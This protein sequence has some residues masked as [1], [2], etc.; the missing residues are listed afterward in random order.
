MN[1]LIGILVLLGAFVTP[2]QFGVP[3]EGTGDASPAL[4]ACIRSGKPIR[5]RKGVSYTLFSKLDRIPGCAFELDGNDATLVID[6]SYPVNAADQIFCFENDDDRRTLFRVK[7]LRIRSHLGPKFSDPQRRGDTYLFYV[8]NCDK[9]EFLNLDIEDDGM[10]NNLSLIVNV[11]ANMNVRNCRMVSRSRSAQGG[12]LWV[13]NK[14]REDLRL[15]MKHVEI[16]YDTHDECLCVAVHAKSQIPSMRLRADIADCRFCGAASVDNPGFVILY[17]HSSRIVPDIEAVFR[18]CSFETQGGLPR[19]VMAFQ[20]TGS[21]SVRD[22]SISADF[23]YCRFVSNPA[24]YSDTGLF[25]L[26]HLTP[27]TSPEQYI[28]R[29]FN[30]TMEASNVCSIIG[31]KDGVTCGTLEFRSCRVNTDGELFVRHYN[32]GAGKLKIR[33]FDS[34]MRCAGKFVTTETLESRRSSFSSETVTE[35][36][37]IKR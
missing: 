20:S 33:T 16:D 27:E 21:P 13:M 11:G 29:F 34:G 9:A 28:I 7:N 37:V 24:I 19:R 3:M 32:P 36:Q 15:K 8:G 35:M 2:E 4:N 23:R 1:L 6:P 5:L 12:A 26:P 25:W 10:Y 30:S 18:N 14:Y 17:S 31:D 22:N